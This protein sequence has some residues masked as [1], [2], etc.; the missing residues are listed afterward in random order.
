[1]LY[2]FRRWVYV[3]CVTEIFIVAESDQEALEAINNLDPI[4]LSYEECPMTHVRSTYEVVKSSDKK[5]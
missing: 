5:S 4:S 2:K 3:P 1:M